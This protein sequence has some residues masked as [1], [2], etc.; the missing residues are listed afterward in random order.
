M[1]TNQWE[2]RV[3]RTT[4]AEFQAWEGS[5]VQTAKTQYELWKNDEDIER[6]GL[7]VNGNLAESPYI[8]SGVRH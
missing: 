4:R 5:D 7:F 3:I 2:V 6:V 1:N 8:R